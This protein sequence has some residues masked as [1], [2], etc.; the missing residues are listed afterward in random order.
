[1]RVELGPAFQHMRATLNS[2]MHVHV[3]AGSGTSEYRPCPSG[4]RPLREQP[5][6]LAHWRLQVPPVHT[7][8]RRRG[9]P[10]PIALWHGP[11]AA[12]RCRGGMGSWRPRRRMMLGGGRPGP[13]ATEWP[14]GGERPQHLPSLSG[15]RAIHDPGPESAGLP[16]Q[17]RV[18]AWISTSEWPCPALRGARCVAV[19]WQ[20]R[21]LAELAHRGARILDEAW[22]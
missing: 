12:G 6:V 14:V 11:R 4:G 21:A 1:V 19:H 2:G 13:V 15:A 16:W 17:G 22:T 3:A 18:G 10:R 20:V 8:A 7:P 5:T 9:R